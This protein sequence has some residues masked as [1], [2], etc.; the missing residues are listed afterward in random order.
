[1]EKKS[2][3]SWSTFSFLF[4]RPNKKWTKVAAAVESRIFTIIHKL[5]GKSVAS[6]GCYWPLY[7]GHLCINI[8]TSAIDVNRKQVPPSSISSERSVLI[9]GSRLPMLPMPMSRNY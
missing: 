6:L 8:S 4:K 5:E 9:S 1:M 2:S 7:L 3:S